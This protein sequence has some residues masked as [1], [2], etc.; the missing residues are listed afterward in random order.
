MK[1]ILD[2]MAPYRRLTQNEI[3]LEQ[4]HGLHK[5]Y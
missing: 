5:A 2:V 3:R 1:D 4:Q